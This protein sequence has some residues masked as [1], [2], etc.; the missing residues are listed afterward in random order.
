MES[1]GQLG[2]VVNFYTKCQSGE[3]YELLRETTSLSLRLLRMTSCVSTIV[4]VDGSQ[5]PNNEMMM[6]CKELDVSYH[7][8]GREVSFVQ[9]Y[10]IG[11]R[12]LDEPYV[13]LM[14]NDIV[15]HPLSTIGVLLDW[16]RRPDVG[17]AFPYLNSNRMHS[18][19]TQRPGFLFRGSVTCEPASMT[20]NLNLF[21]R[22]VLEQINGLDENYVFGYSEP[23]LLIN[24]RSLGARAVLVGGTRAFHY[25]SLTRSLQESSLDLGVLR[26][27]IR[28]WCRE[29]PHHASKRG[30]GNIN[31]AKAPFATTCVAKG[32]WWLCYQCP[33][34]RVRRRMMDLM[35]CIEPLVTRYPARY[36]AIHLK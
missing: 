32:L 11:W 35:M 22:S 14:A 33:I 7:H 3:H 6:R 8:P 28:R 30:I 34:A 9:A 36:G 27:D 17:C 25:D 21:K 12:H 5:H 23:I 15:P 29:Y 10:N 19:E 26:E 31:F 24:I 4:L 20:L 2:M 13:G 18:D 1:D 16:V